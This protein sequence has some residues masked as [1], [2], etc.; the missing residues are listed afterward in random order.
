MNSVPIITCKPWNPVPKQKHEPK[1]P[2]LIVN[3]ETEY[4]T[5]WKPVNINANTIVNNAPYKAPFLFPCIKE[6]CEY[7]IVTNSQIIALFISTT[8]VFYINNN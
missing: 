4:S 8:P 5:P 3:E 7:V 2:S 1:A 6:W